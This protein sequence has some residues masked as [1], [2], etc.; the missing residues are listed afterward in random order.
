MENH[1]K[2]DRT[3]NGQD[4]LTNNNKNDRTNNDDYKTVRAVDR[5]LDILQCFVDAN[6]L[7]LTDIAKRVSLN[8]STV[9]RLLSTLEKRGFLARNSETDKYRL[10][11]RMWELSINMSF[12]DD[13]A[14]LFLPEMTSL[15]DVLGETISLYVRD[16][17]ERVR[18]QAVESNQTIRRV[19]PI[20]ARM[21]LSVGAS[22]K[23]LVAY[24]DQEFQEKVLND[25]AWPDSVDKQ[26]Y[27]QQLAEIRECGYATS[28]EEREPGTSAVAA[29][30]FNRSGQL[31]AALAVS[32]P[33]G[34]LT[35]DKMKEYS[36]RI[37]E[38]AARMGKL[39]RS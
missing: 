5:A 23:V 7:S 14:K 37:M 8:K 24:A 17:M 29:P 30:I 11:L 35:L 4:E 38:A 32:G 33:A 16:G 21:P 28:I 10:G 12:A 3:A 2:N 25:P 36:P 31:I 19:A 15:R 39:I 13:P 22:S 9:F 20:G 26:A 34:R 1:K 6:E 27:I 18:V